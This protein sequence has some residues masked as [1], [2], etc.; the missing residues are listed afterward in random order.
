[1]NHSTGKP[2]RL[3]QRRLELLSQMPCIACGLQVQA[4]RTEIHHLV[5]R[6]YRVH[7][8]GHLAT[9]PL[10][11]WH[12]RGVCLEGWPLVAMVST[13]GPSMA[14]SKRAFVACYGS[15]RALL[16]IVDAFL[17]SLWWWGERSVLEWEAPLVA[18]L[19]PPLSS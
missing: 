12:H 5:D 19:Y 16:S 18:R 4:G 6:G 2:S 10:C 3:E 17:R 7:S 15:E 13:F 1:M 14:S 11:S 9:I 8:G